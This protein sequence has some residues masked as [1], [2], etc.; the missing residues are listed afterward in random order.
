MQSR[1]FGTVM[2]SFG[3]L[4][5]TLSEVSWVQGEESHRIMS[6]F[7]WKLMAGTHGKP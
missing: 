1:T 5:Y 7:V 4:V 3:W 2:T 6:A